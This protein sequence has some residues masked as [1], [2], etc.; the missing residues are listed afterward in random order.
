MP[1]QHAAASRD[2]SSSVTTGT[3]PGRGSHSSYTQQSDHDGHRQPASDRVVAIIEN[4]AKEVVTFSSFMAAAH[5]RLALHSKFLSQ[6]G[7][8]HLCFR[9]VWL[10]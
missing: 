1:V 2:L 8:P 10:P 3:S 7:L 4:R 9:L 5:S 6:T